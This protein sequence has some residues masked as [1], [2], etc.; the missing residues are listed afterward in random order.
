VKVGEGWRRLENVGYF[1][2]DI[3]EMFR[4]YLAKVGD[5]DAVKSTPKTGQDTVIVH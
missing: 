4:S 2:G 3:S 1:L 5:E